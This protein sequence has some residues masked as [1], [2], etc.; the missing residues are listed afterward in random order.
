MERT[1]EIVTA[2]LAVLKSGGTYVPI[3]ISFP[4]D[5]IEFILKDADIKV[6][7]TNVDFSVEYEHKVNVVNLNNYKLSENNYSNFQTNIN[8]GNLAYIIYTSGSTG[9]PKGVMVPHSALMN[10][11]WSMRQEPGF[12]KDDVL[13][14]V[15]PISFDIAALE[16]FL[17][18]ITGGTVVVAGKE[19]MS[20]P[21]LIAEA[22]SNYNIS[23]M[24]ATPAT[25]QLLVDTGW[26]GKPALKALCGG[27]VLTRKPA[28]QLL[29]RAGGLWN[30][31]GPTETTIWSSVEQI[32]KG[33]SP[34]TIGKPID[35]TQLY[36]LDRNLEP[37]PVGVIG[38]L[39]IGGEGLAK[40]YLNRDSLTNE[41]FI[42]DPFGSTTGARL[43]KTGDRA[44]HLHD[45][46]IELLGRNDD[47]VKLNGHRIE[48]GEVS[49][50][51]LQ[52]PTISEV[53]TIIQTDSVSG[54][55]KLVAYFVPK[56]ET[57]AN[58][59]ELKNFIS[60]K[61]PAYMI[62]AVFVSLEKIPLTPNGKIDRRS[63]PSTED[64]YQLPGYMAPRDKTEQILAGIWK[65]VLHINQAGINDNFF[66]L[67]GASIQSLELVAK[68]N[69]S[70]LN[71]SV[72]DVFRYQTI[73]ELADNIK[74]KSQ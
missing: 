1:S 35:N 42:P 29:G 37:V 13:L 59:N 64:I 47:Q 23:I 11:L 22:I 74:I 33:E 70:G 67:G 26:E 45:Y 32:L 68:A 56:V 39:H 60:R 18:L 7:I 9:Q 72:E 66:D 49:S 16:L 51:L 4:V 28:N 20:N 24:Q 34:I 2:L 73:A 19:I 62:P 41:K 53:V 69:I 30:M 27:D 55:K 3:N 31:Y 14:A 43:Y 10:F 17:P 6:L 57:P 12:N 54:D 40:G 46:S 58:E 61:L 44:R 36:I 65:D 8:P 25:W 5:R 71:I 52:H 48:L 38:E 63:L 15:T 50:V 21:F